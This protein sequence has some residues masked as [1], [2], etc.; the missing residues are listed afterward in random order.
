MTYFKYAKPGLS[1]CFRSI[2]VSGRC[3][4]QWVANLSTISA[5]VARVL[6][7]ISPVEPWPLQNAPALSFAIYQHSLLPAQAPSSAAN[8][9]FPC[10]PPQLLPLVD[11][12]EIQALLLLQLCCWARESEVS[13]HK[14]QE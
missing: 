3:L 11:F 2:P 9:S 14:C 4:L 5:A 6:L 12:K 13:G 7:C 1:V 8:H 10:Y